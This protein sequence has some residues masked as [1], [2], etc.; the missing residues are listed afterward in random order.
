[1]NNFNSLHE[2]LSEFLQLEVAMSECF[3]QKNN[4]RWREG[5]LKTSFIYLLIDPRL[6][7]NLPLIHKVNIS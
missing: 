6:A 1:M 7:Q 4:V 3:Q 2:N 5:H